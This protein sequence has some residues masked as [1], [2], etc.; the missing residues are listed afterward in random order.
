MV[1]LLFFRIIS[2]NNEFTLAIDIMKKI[3]TL[4]FLLC[5]ASVV[6]QQTP[7]KLHVIDNESRGADGVRLADVNGDGH[8]DLVTGWEEGGKVRLCLNPGPSKAKNKWKS[9]TVGNVKSPEDAVFVDLDR[10]GNVDVVSCCEGRTMSVFIHWAP[11]AKSDYLKESAWKTEAFPVL[12]KKARW[13]YAV[14]ADM[15]GDGRVDLVIGAKGGKAELGWLEAPKNARSLKDWKWHAITPVGWVMSIRVLDLDEDG[16]LDV[17]VSDR[18]GPRR[19]CRWLENPGRGDAW[20]SH[21]I[22]AKGEGVMFLDLAD[23]NKDGFQDVIVPT[24]GRRLYILDREGKAASWK[25]RQ[26]S[27]PQQCGTGKAIRVG[28]LNQDGKPDMVLTGR[29]GKGKHGIV[30]LSAPKWTIHTLSGPATKKTYKPDRIELVDLDGDGDLDVITSE[31][32]SLL[33]VIW[34]ENPQR[35]PK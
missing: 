8:L 16:D 20:K 25:S 3:L 32:R 14:P 34:Y 28:D 30:W 19:G 9:V 18:K 7:W 4:S 6:A 2:T 31:E 26:I 17:V 10:D 12:Q 11:K 22:G 35:S 23:L 29:C 21:Y 27:Y 24:Y 15:N 5:T 13:M 33:G 1:L